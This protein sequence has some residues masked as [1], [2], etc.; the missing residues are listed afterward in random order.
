MSGESIRQTKNRFTSERVGDNSSINLLIPVDNLR[1]WNALASK[2]CPFAMT[3][4]R[5]NVMS[6][7]TA[8]LP[9]CIDSSLYPAFSKEVKQRGSYSYMKEGE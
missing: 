7:S 4:R 6:G 2:A 9:S 5:K 1:T 3:V 8:C